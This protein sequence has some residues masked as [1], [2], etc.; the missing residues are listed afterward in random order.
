[1]IVIVIIVTML[2]DVIRIYDVNLLR[3]ASS[4]LLFYHG[5]YFAVF[6]Y[7]SALM[8]VMLLEYSASK[9]LIIVVSFFGFV[10]SLPLQYPNKLDATYLETFMANIIVM[11][12]AISFGFLCTLVLY[13]MIT[14]MYTANLKL[15]R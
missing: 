2:K 4:L 14:L 15:L 3:G 9:I 7:M 1:M 12:F 8:S 11:T 10:F 6:I 13:L 5:M